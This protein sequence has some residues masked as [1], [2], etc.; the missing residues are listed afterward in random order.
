MPFI[1]YSDASGFGIGA[2]LVQ[3]I[4]GRESV[5]SWICRKLS[6]AEL[7]YTTT[8]KEF[9]A[10]V[11]AI[12]RF[13]VYLFNNFIVKTD[14]SALKWLL[15]QKEP[16]GR[17]ARWIMAL[18]EYKYQVQH[19]SGKENVIADA[20]SRGILKSNDKAN[21]IV[22]QVALVDNDKMLEATARAHE[23][24][25]HACT[26]GV[27]LYLKKQY[28]YPKMRDYIKEFINRCEVCQKFADKQHR[29][30]IVR[31]AIKY[32]SCPHR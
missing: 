14:H 25:G 32:L 8:E 3:N 7:N 9:L 21:L 23:D 6:P 2:A 4:D 31:I 12:K 10:V 30:K 24:L 27:Y 17:L 22:T 28:N 13:K 26:E 5:V 20:L 15:K 16:E 19:I 18:Q 1:I 29:K 11:W